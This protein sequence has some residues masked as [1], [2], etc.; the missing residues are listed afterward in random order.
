MLCQPRHLSAVAVAAVLALPAGGIAHAGNSAVAL[1]PCS[2]EQ[3]TLS[4]AGTGTARPGG[5]GNQDTAV[6]R[7]HNKGSMS[8][9]LRGYPDVTLK[10]RHETE[11]LPDTPRANPRT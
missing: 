10:A 11:T 8:C 2:A 5:T 7:V 6:V 9:T 3:L 1:P 4:W